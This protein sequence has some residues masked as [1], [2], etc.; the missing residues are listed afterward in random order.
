MG[1]AGR[2]LL[3]SFD[4]IMRTLHHS[5]ADMADP[6]AALADLSYDAAK[7]SR[8]QETGVR[9]VYKRGPGQEQDIYDGT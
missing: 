2:Y 3:V 1:R 7:R 8:L 4:V 6:K 9:L 5:S